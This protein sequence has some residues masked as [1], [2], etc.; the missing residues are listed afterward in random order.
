MTFRTSI[1]AAANPIKGRY[2]RSRSLQANLNIGAPIMSRFDL[3]FV[4]VDERDEFL[5]NS[6]A[7]HIVNLHRK[8][9]EGIKP[10]FSQKEMLTYLKFCR[11]IKPRFTHDAAELLSNEFVKLRQ[12]DGTAKKTSYRITVR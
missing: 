6:I 1:L 7:Q 11:T 5:D 2:D 8:K 12:N 10:Y 9:D 3:F 4:V